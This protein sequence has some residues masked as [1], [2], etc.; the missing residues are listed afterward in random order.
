MGDG[1]REVL[2]LIGFTL[3]CLALLLGA[4]KLFSPRG[5]APRP[6]GPP[7][8]AIPSTPPDGV[9]VK[10]LNYTSVG[11]LEE[12]VLVVRIRN[13]HPYPVKV[14]LETPQGFTD[15]IGVAPGDEWKLVLPLEPH[16]TGI[17]FTVAV[18]F[19]CRDGAVAE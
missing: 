7:I 14:W 3:L 10:V 9:R 1:A 2:V 11:T 4:Y 5:E 18:G 16:T 17:W 6:P 12:P 8:V 13:G 15:P 19:S